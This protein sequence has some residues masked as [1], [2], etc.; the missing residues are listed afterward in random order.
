MT[1]R[2]SRD[3]WAIEM[4][5][6]VARRST[7]LRRAVG[8]VLLSARGHVLATG[9]NGVAAGLPHCNE[10]KTVGLDYQPSIHDP[11]VLIPSKLGAHYP[12]ACPGAQS[13]SG[14]NLDGCQ[15]IHAEQNALLQCRDPYVIDTCYCTTLPCMT[16]I[17]LLMNTSCRRLV[18]VDL[19]P[20]NGV[21]PLWE[22]T[23]RGWEQWGGDEIL[24]RKAWVQT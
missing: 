10:K 9:Y 12:H 21:I 4:A 18:F 2:L 15:A 6:L 11:E 7:C 23:G 14:T 3:A 5:R 22:K 13:P 24:K 16:C 20:H 8:C 19:Y 17:K 1:D